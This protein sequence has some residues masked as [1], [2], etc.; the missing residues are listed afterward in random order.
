MSLKPFFYKKK[1]DGVPG[2]LGI[3]GK[4]KLKIKPK[5]SHGLDAVRQL[6]SY[7]CKPS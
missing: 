4:Q 1:L 6:F 5:I 2:V 7:I 3:L